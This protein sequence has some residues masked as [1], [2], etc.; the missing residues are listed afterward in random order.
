VVLLASSF[1]GWGPLWIAQGSGAMHGSAMSGHGPFAL[2]GG[3]VV[4]VG[5]ALLAWAARIRNR[6][7][8]NLSSSV[9][10]RGQLDT[11]YAKLSP[12]TSSKR[13]GTPP[14]VGPSKKGA[15]DVVQ[16]LNGMSRG[17]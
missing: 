2:L 11:F 7:H 16:A 5:L 12:D 14:H 9:R 4:I 13:D 15:R 17:Q 8:L 3:A 10:T 1:A 6:A